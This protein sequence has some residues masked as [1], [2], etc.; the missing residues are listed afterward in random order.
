MIP[1]L[2]RAG[3]T[4]GGSITVLLTSCLTGLESAVWQQTILF[5]FAK[6]TNPSQW[7]QEVDG[8]VILPPLVFP[9]K[10]FQKFSGLMV[11]KEKIRFVFKI[12]PPRRKKWLAAPALL[13]G[14]LSLSHFLARSLSLLLFIY[15][16]PHPIFTLVKSLVKSS[17]GAS[18]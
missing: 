10:R 17:A 8:T 15:R 2:V 11:R 12:D 5:L 18:R 1:L 7:K 9:G 13:L 4:I 3:N 6:Q 16:L 14:S